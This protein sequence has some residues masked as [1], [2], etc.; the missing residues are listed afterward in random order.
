MVRN[1]PTR[2]AIKEATCSY[3]TPPAAAPLRLH[4]IGRTWARR[5]CRTCRGCSGGGPRGARRFHTWR[6]SQSTRARAARSGARTARGGVEGGTEA[7]VGEAVR[8]QA[9]ARRYGGG[10]GR[11]ERASVGISA[12]VLGISAAAGASGHQCCSGGI[13]AVVGAAAR[14]SGGIS[15]HQWGHQRASV[16]A[17]ARISGGISGA[18][19]LCGAGGWHGCGEHRAMQRYQS[20][21]AY[22]ITTHRTME[23]RGR[24]PAKAFVA[25]LKN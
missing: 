19:G 10:C 24:V 25:G 6:H 7:G 22:Q 14:I 15:A 1:Q 3:L 8:R 2:Q 9:W 17:S 20:I 23:G 21:A 4:A 16:G 18:C 12:V 5:R 13:S 11:G